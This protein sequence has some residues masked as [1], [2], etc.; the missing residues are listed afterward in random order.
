MNQFINPNSQPK[1]SLATR[2]FHHGSVLLIIAVWALIALSNESNNLIA[3]HKALGAVFL[4]WTLLRLVNILFRPK[5]PSVVQPIWQ[6]VAAHLVY[7][8][9]YVAML[10][11]PVLGILMSVYGGRSVNIF[12]LFEIPVFVT[13][14]REMASFYNYLHTEVVFPILLVLIALHIAAALYHQFIVK[15]NILSRMR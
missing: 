5:L 2:I 4:L 15:D 8:G 9:L 12:G 6:T 3:Y 11:M 13:P 1:H 14:N 7:F 10:A